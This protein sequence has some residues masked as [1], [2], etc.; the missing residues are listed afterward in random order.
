MDISSTSNSSYSRSVRP[1]NSSSDRQS[2]DESQM[3]ITEVKT[4]ERA[5]QQKGVQ[6]GLQQSSEEN[7]RRLDGRL[8]SFGYEHNDADNRQQQASVNRSRVNDAYSTPAQNE[9]TYS[10]EQHEQQRSSE[11][12]ADAIDI[13]V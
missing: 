8:I 13:V 7:E 10:Q 6:E 3:A 9:R 2:K 1:S 5:Q 4:Q 12:D 11:R